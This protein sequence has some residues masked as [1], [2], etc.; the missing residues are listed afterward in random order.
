MTAT[1][2]RPPTNGRLARNRRTS[3]PRRGAGAPTAVGE[4][5]IEFGNGSH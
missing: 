3:D 4:Y 5:H 1:R 2:S